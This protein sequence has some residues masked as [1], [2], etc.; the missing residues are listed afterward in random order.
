MEFERREAPYLAP[1]ANVAGIM[2]QVLLALVEEHA[3]APWFSD[4]LD[5][6]A[7]EERALGAARTRELY[8]LAVE[9][10]RGDN[11][12][13]ALIALARLH[14][15]SKADGARAAACQGGRTHEKIQRR[16]AKQDPRSQEQ[17]PA[18]SR[19]GV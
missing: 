12:A 17:V 10:A 1:T 8:E 15:A 9:H 18:P 14:R 6:I 4:V 16:R 3:G 2:Q 7:R 13:Q 19:G 11:Q 5:Q